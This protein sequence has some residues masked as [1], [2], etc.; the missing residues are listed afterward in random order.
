[1][2]TIQHTCFPNG[3]RAGGLT[4]LPS[5]FS[6]A[7]NPNTAQR[8]TTVITF[9]DNTTQSTSAMNLAAMMNVIFGN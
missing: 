2:A 9:P 6:D 8:A 1:M 5:T 4:I 7:A 3:I